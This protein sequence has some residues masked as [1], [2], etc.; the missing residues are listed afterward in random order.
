MKQWKDGRSA[1]ESARAW[2]E[3]AP[4][5]V[6]AEIEQALSAHPDFGTILPGWSAEPEA[7]VAFDSFG[8]E[9]SNLDVLL[10]TSDEEG[11]LVIAVEAKADEPFGN[12]VEKTLCQ[13]RKRK[14]ENPA[15][16]GV[17]RV[18]Q[19]AAAILGVPGHK[20]PEVGELRYQLLTASAAALA[21][22]QRRCVGR[23]V[24]IIHEFAS[25]QTSC[26]KHLENAEDLNAFVT[27]LSDGEVTSVAEGTVRGPFELPGHP[28]IDSQI[29]FYIGKAVRNLRGSSG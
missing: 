28:L 1:K 24:L 12:T 4:D 20:L 21:E 9:P 29:R 7:R 2:L 25:D 14:A 10:T 19:L 17:D 8:G 27:K 15:S 13:A 5:C 16:R 6:P 23:A 26:Q 3:R 22:A 18:E 11:Q